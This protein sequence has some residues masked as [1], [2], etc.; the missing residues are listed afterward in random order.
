MTLGYTTSKMGTREYDL[1][2]ILFSRSSQVTTPD[3]SEVDMSYDSSYSGFPLQFPQPSSLTNPLMSSMCSN[4]AAA[5]VLCDLMTRHCLYHTREKTF[6][7]ML[8]LQNKHRQ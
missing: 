6:Q 2:A 1:F 8:V 7:N 4:A 5:Q 3:Y